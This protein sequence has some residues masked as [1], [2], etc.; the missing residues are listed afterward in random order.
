MR[1][2]DRQGKPPPGGLRFYQPETNFFPTPWSSFDSC[3]AQIIKHRLGNPWLIDKNG[4]SV[5]PAVVAN[6]LDAFNT[7]IC[8]EMKWTDYIV[9]GDPGDPS[10]PFPIPQPGS[11]WSFSS[12]LSRFGRNVAEGVSTIAEWEIAGGRVVSKETANARAITCA[13]CPK[14][15]R[16]YLLDYFTAAAA[17]LILLQLETKNKMHLETASDEFLGICDAC[18]CVN[19]LKVWCPM[20]IINLKLKPEIRSQLDPKCWITNEKPVLPD[21]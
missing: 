20:D 6:D 19:K 15:L 2:K 17:R 11:Q 18:G 8:V 7:K 4:W 16:T 10:A 9:E 14:N 21:T 12:Q 1:L 5:D 3:V 13:H